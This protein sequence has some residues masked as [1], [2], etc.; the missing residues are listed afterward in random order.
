MVNDHRGSA[1]ELWKGPRFRSFLCL[2]SLALI[3]SALSLPV[4]TY[5]QLS[6]LSAVSQVTDSGRS[7]VC[8]GLLRPGAVFRW[9]GRGMG[10]G[11]A[12]ILP[13]P[14]VEGGGVCAWV[15]DWLGGFGAKRL[16]KQLS[17]THQKIQ[18]C[19]P[20]PNICSPATM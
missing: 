13:R 16:Q 6:N 12:E 2:P 10:E 1:L 8:Q 14:G 19:I 4:P 5:T 7:F 20:A 9:K 15:D 3:C 11:T 17:Q 18:A